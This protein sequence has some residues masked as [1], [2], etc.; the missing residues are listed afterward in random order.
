[1]P[2]V[3]YVANADSRDISVAH[4]DAAAGTLTEVQ[5]AAAPGTIGPLALHPARTRLYAALRSEPFRAVT[6]A[7]APGT[8][9]IAP[10]AT[11]PLPDNMCYISPD[12]RGRFLFGASYSGDRISINPIG[13]DGLM[14]GRPVQVLATDP[15]PHSIVADPTN[16]YVLVPCLGGDAILQFVFDETTGRIAPNPAAARAEVGRKAG[17]RH[18]VF[19]PN[20]RL[21][22]G[23]NELDATAGAYRFDASTGTLTPV[24]TRTLLPPGFE[25]TPPFAAADLHVTPDGRHLYASER[26]SNRLTG[27]QIDA[28]SGALAPAGSVPVET[29]PRGFNIDPRGRYLL[30]VGQVSNQMTIYA[31]DADS[32]TLTPHRRYPMGRNPHWVEIVDIA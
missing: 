21:A 27:F 15:H 5:R 19:H 9:A 12:R 30:A 2:T 4:F 8:G 14:D 13:P 1:M 24:G 26:V 17:P 29:K 28:E 7:I 31:I 25:G 11:A 22:Y 3:V 23:T 10:L 6:F 16:R 32:G 20:G 18:L